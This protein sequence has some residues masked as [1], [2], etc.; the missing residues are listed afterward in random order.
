MEHST[1]SVLPLLVK[2]ALQRNCT[3]ITKGVIMEAE[4]RYKTVTRELLSADR[5]HL[6][7]T[8]QHFLPNFWL[9]WIMCHGWF[10]YWTKGALACG[11]FLESILEE[12]EN[13]PMTFQKEVLYEF[14]CTVLF[15]YC[16]DNPGCGVF[17]VL[18]QVL[19]RAVDQFPNNLH[20]LAILA[21]EQSLTKNMG[22]SGWK[23]ENLLLKTGRAIPTVFAV[24]IQD[25]VRFEIENQALDSITGM[26]YVG[27]LIV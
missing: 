4:T 6:L 9:D 8:P 13:K 21:K 22:I 2:L 12:L 1:K 27:I 26:W 24:L 11:T 10:L 17:K 3:N 25:L 14:Y 19:F 23:V 16:S 15:K 7:T 5:E 18:D 20:L